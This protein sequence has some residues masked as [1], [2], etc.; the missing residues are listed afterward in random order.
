MKVEHFGGAAEV[1]DRSALDSLLSARYGNDV[2]EYLLGGEETYPY[3]MILVRGSVAYLH[4]FPAEGHA[5]FQSLGDGGAAGTEAFYTN[6]PT[7]PIWVPA[8]AVVPFEQ[9]REAAHEYLHSGLIP[10]SVRW[11]ALQNE[12]TIGAGEQGR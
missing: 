10:S 2:N 7:E 11:R 5:G 6:K 1:T 3:L 4:F 9:A 12:K 8:D